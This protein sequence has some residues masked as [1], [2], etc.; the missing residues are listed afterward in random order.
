MYDPYNKEFWAATVPRRPQYSEILRNKKDSPVAPWLRQAQYV[1]AISTGQVPELHAEDNLLNA[2][3][4]K[5]NEFN[6]V[7]ASDGKRRYLMF[8]PDP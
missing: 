3:L 6:D 7:L 5:R 4:R 2:Y 1:N 8:F